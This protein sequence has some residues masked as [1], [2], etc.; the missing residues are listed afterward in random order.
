[1]S[2]TIHPSNFGLPVP[3]SFDRNLI[4]VI[5][6]FGMLPLPSLPLALIQNK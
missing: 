6:L 4:I 2:E 5:K 1:M 3:G